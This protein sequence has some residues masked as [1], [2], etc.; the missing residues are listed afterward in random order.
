MLSFLIYLVSVSDP[1]DHSSSPVFGAAALYSGLFSVP[2]H[3]LCLVGGCLC[4]PSVIKFQ[5]VNLAH[6]YFD[7]MVCKLNKHNF[8]TRVTFKISVKECRNFLLQHEN[9]KSPT[10]NFNASSISI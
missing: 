5:N 10:K 4:S 9:I 6:P 7:G 3:R 2:F 1:M 8:F